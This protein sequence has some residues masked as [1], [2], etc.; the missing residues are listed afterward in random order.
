MKLK[1]PRRIE[2]RKAVEV[3]GF[4]CRSQ[5]IH[6]HN[7]LHEFAAGTYQSQVIA[8]EW[9]QRFAPEIRF[10][11]TVKATSTNRRRRSRP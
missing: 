2:A 5:V 3:I 1:T 10:G 7:G 11:L 8:F 4:L 9:C 6:R